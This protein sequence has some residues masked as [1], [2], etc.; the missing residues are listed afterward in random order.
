MPFSPLCEL[1]RLITQEKKTTEFN[2]IGFPRSLHNLLAILRL[3]KV[4]ESYKAKAQ[5]E[6]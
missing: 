2:T 6:P 1:F 3:I 5:N 4:V